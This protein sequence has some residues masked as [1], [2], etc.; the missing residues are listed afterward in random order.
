MT[1]KTVV[2]CGYCNQVLPAFQINLLRP[3]D[4]LVLTIADT[5]PQELM[6]KRQELVEV[7]QEQVSSIYFLFQ[8]T[9]AV[10]VHQCRGS[11]F[12]WPFASL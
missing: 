5:P 7:L 9:N 10:P 4:G 3:G 6:D 8:Y 1:D 12:D 2:T 11:H